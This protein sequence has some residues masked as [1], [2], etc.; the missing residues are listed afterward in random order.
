MIFQKDRL[1]QLVRDKA[2]K[3]APPNK[4]FTLTSG[5][6]SRFYLDCRKVTLDPEGAHIIGVGIISIIRGCWKDMPNV[7][8][9]GGPT[10]GADPVVTATV[11]ASSASIG[12]PRGAPTNHQN[13]H[14]IVGFLIRKEA[15]GHGIGKFIVGPVEPGMRSVIVEDVCTTGGSALEAIR[16]TEE[17]GMSVMGVI[18]VVNRLEGAEELLA[19]HGY[20]LYN[21]IT[22]E[23][24]GVT[25]ENMQTTEITG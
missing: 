13:L 14:S 16:K 25:K 3:I 15:K 17:F 8:A 9:V 24:I 23:D 5:K 1:I 21:L 20:K 10:I 12:F 2:L 19:E 22:S 6:K 18:G 4:E 11:L 7:E